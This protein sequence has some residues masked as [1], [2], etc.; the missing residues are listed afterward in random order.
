[1]DGLH[2]SA[3]PKT[4]F[5]IFIYRIFYFSFQ[6][7]MIKLHFIFKLCYSFLLSLTSSCK[8]EISLS[9]IYTLLNHIKFGIQVPI[10]VSFYSPIS[11]PNSLDHCCLPS[12]PAYN[13][14]LWNSFY[15][16]YCLCTLWH[17]SSSLNLFFFSPGRGQIR[18][19][20]HRNNLNCKGV[21]N[22]L[23]IENRKK[24]Y[25]Y[26]ACLKPLQK[27]LCKESSTFSISPITTTCYQKEM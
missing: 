20:I 11:I 19:C 9:F 6:T 4:S 1:M 3:L 5:Q 21:G 23:D 26:L 27:I 22:T 18:I 10:T 8:T 16:W 7:S 2:V 24:S 12:I 17:F 25:N 13:W 15:I 14:K